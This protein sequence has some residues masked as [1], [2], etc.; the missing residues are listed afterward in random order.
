MSYEQVKVAT[1]RLPLEVPNEAE[2]LPSTPWETAIFL[3][4]SRNSPGD[5]G[6]TMMIRM[7]HARREILE[8]DLD[9]VKNQNRIKRHTETLT[10][11]SPSAFAYNFGNSGGC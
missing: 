5:Q 1:Q 2:V 11:R 10:L 7:M 4:L 6:S 8:G 9:T 3:H